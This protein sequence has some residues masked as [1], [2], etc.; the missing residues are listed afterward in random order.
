M[1]GE[2]EGERVKGRERRPGLDMDGDWA[3]SFVFLSPSFVLFP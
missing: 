2:S 3:G 1:V